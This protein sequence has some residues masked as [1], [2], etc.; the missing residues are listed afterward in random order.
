[1]IKYKVQ[2]I[3]P[4]CST[5]LST[6]V[7]SHSAQQSLQCTR[8][9]TS[10][11]FPDWSQWLLQTMKCRNSYLYCKTLAPSRRNTA[12]PDGGTFSRPSCTGLPSG[13]MSSEKQAVSL[14]SRQYTD[15]GAVTC[16]TI[17]MWP[18]AANITGLTVQCLEP[19]CNIWLT[20]CAHVQLQVMGKELGTPAWN[21]YTP[22]H[23]SNPQ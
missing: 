13:V 12:F 11:Y 14:A 10:T 16:K 5:H 15:P 19:F 7:P 21:I 23:V 3:F 6:T 2:C 20:M 22:Q 17:N 4:Y 1:M 8:S 18:T 9:A